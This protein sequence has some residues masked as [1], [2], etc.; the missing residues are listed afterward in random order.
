MHA[1]LSV[2]CQ[3]NREDAQCDAPSHATRDAEGRGGE[4]LT[5]APL[6]RDLMLFVNPYT[7]R[8][9]QRERQRQRQRQRQRETYR[10]SVD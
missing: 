3:H 10:H 2:Y 7:D 4:H 1:R 8:Q 5:H 6:K 9:R